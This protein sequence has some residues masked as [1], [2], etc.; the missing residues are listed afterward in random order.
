MTATGAA[1]RVMPAELYHG[2]KP[3][4]E[5][6]DVLLPP[7]ETGVISVTRMMREHDTTCPDCKRI[8]PAKVRFTE[9]SE[10][11]DS[12][13]YAGPLASAAAHAGLWTINPFREGSGY[14]YKIRPLGTCVPDAHKAP[15]DGAW[16][17]ERAV[18][19]QV[20]CRGVPRE[21]FVRLGL[22]PPENAEIYLRHVR[23]WWPGRRTAAAP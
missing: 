3:G 7:S 13:V 19:E 14:V 16:Q 22:E 23:E 18:V 12:W 2:G 1:P 15:P 21:I 6:G 10:G 5:A 20:I 11:E 4:L 9:D 17:C 8:V